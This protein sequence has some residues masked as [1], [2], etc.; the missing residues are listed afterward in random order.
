MTK[1]NQSTTQK[2]ILG[3]LMLAGWFALVSQ[4]YININSKAAALPELITRYF[5]YFTILTNLIVAIYCTV[6]LLNPRSKPGT[7]FASYRTSTAITVYILIV[8]IIYNIILRSIW[9]PQGLQLLVDELLHSVIP[10]LFLLYWICFVPK[11]NLKRQ[12][13]LPWLIYPLLY[14]ILILVRGSFS[15][16]YPYPFINVTNLGLQQVLINAAGI[17]AIFIAVSLLFIT[18]G[19]LMSK[20]NTSVPG[21]A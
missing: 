12:E 17:T 4:F 5:S 15:G 13:L 6:L 19:N 16:F 14:I 10:V 21:K 1:A 7:F 8:G 18:M 3:F 20:K 9:N 2:Y 11:Q